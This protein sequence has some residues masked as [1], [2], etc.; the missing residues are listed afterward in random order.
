M[1]LLLEYVRSVGATKPKPK[2]TETYTPPPLSAHTW[3]CREAI[4]WNRFDVVIVERMQ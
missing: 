1:T 4:M 2:P 3:E